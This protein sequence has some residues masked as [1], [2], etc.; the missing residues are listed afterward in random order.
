MEPNFS[1]ILVDKNSSF[2]FTESDIK[3]LEQ[4]ILI[5]ISTI[6]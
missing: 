5:Y 4:D 2:V 1:P 3:S 6:H